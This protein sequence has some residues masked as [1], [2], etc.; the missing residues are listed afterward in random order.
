MKIEAQPIFI[1]GTLNNGGR[2]L[3][4]VGNGTWGVNGFAVF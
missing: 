4:S 3:G 2:N 1:D